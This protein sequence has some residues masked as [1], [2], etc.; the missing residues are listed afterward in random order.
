MIQVSKVNQHPNFNVDTFINDIA[1][2]QLSQNL[3]LG[4]SVA[5]IIMISSSD[6]VPEGV[7]A[8]ATGWGKLSEGGVVPDQLQVPIYTR[9]EIDNVH[10]EVKRCYIST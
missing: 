5:K 7:P 1:V 8:V 9:L 2:L 4:I 10:G 3:K 6:L